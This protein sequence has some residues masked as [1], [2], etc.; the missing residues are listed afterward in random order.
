MEIRSPLDI[1]GAS[2]LDAIEN[3]QH[4]DAT[5]CFH[6]LQIREFDIL[7]A[8]RFTKLTNKHLEKLK[9]SLL[10]NYKKFECMSKLN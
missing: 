7:E 1:T 2:R 4:M 3:C 6:Y 5:Q 8:Y 9:S 10:K